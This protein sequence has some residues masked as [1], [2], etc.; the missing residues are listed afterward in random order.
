L[1]GELQVFVNTEV[2]VEEAYF[3]ICSKKNKKMQFFVI[4]PLTK[5]G[6]SG[7]LL[8]Y[9]ADNVYGVMSW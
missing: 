9:K 2:T 1:I 8:F 6:K 5:R 3:K 7:R 4:F